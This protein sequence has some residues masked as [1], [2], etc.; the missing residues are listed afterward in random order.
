MGSFLGLMFEP[1]GLYIR[2]KLSGSKVSYRQYW[3]AHSNIWIDATLG[4]LVLVLAIFLI[5]EAALLFD[6]FS[7]LDS[8]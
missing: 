8:V 4:I 1:L 5:Y 6:S 7:T 2:W 3:E